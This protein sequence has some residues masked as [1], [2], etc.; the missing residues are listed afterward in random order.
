M[1]NKHNKKRFALK[2]F[3]N[4]LSRQDYEE[5]IKI[6]N[7]LHEIFNNKEKLDTIIAQKVA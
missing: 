4:L 1:I 3:K 2:K 5:E 6:M 7:N